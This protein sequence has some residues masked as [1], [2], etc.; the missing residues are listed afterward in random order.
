MKFEENW[1][2]LLHPGE[3][4]AKPF[5]RENSLLTYFLYQVIYIDFE[6]NNPGSKNP[7]QYSHY[8]GCGEPEASRMFC[9]FWCF[10]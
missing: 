7:I 5:F 10:V 6:I 2:L 9:T 4:T 1:F 3:Y 8:C